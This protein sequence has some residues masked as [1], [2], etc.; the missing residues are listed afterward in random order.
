LPDLVAAAP[1]V[2]PRQKPDRSA[3]TGLFANTAT[4]TALVIDLGFAVDNRK[5][6]IRAGYFTGV[7]SGTLFNVYFDGQ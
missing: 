7:T 3:F 6:G 4:D 5:T 1:Q 2:L